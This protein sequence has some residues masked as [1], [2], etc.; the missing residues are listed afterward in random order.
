MLA[1]AA[2]P[3]GGAM[4]RMLGAESS[5]AGKDEAQVWGFG[6]GH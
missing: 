5:R 6:R 4:I 2:D 1:R 3:K